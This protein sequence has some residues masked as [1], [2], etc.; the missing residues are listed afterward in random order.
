[1]VQVTQ[2]QDGK[3]RT[4]IRTG[5]NKWSLGPGS[6]GVINPPA[7][8][9]T[10]HRLGELTAAGWVGHEITAPE[11]YGLNPNN[12]ALTVELKSGQKLSVDFGAELPRAQT[13]LA[14]VDFD[15]RRWVFVFP[16]VLYQLVAAYLTI[17][18]TAP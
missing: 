7:V 8:E 11:K 13:A 18:P 1:V 6:Q 4:L 16:P 12:L 14:S 2:R 5:E 15:G 17:P 9:E 10:L 3:T